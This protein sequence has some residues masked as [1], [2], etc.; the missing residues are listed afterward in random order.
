MENVGLS[1]LVIFLEGEVVGSPSPR[2]LSPALSLG[3]RGA[4]ED[5]RAGGEAGQPLI[6]TA[7]PSTSRS[8]KS[9]K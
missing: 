3:S 2:S 7:G 1:A 6:H 9:P 5:M 8:A 4:R